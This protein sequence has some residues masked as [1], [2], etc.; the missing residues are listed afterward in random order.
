MAICL[1]SMSD[2]AIWHQSR[3]INGSKSVY[4]EPTRVSEAR[5]GH[6]VL[7]RTSDLDHPPSLVQVAFLILLAATTGTWVVA[8]NLALLKRAVNKLDV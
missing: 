8:P 2:L 3:N 5:H 6:T 7:R 4:R 1:S